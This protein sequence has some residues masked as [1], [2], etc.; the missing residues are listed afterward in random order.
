MSIL[1]T[2]K[3]GRALKEAKSR[4]EGFFTPE[5]VEG[6]D[7]EE[8]AGLMNQIVSRVN[9]DEVRDARRRAVQFMLVLFVVGFVCGSVTTWLVPRFS[10]LSGIE[11]ALVKIAERE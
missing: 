1:D 5:F 2:Q 7:P 3:M 8:I 6:R 11:Q 10:P 9:H 4:S